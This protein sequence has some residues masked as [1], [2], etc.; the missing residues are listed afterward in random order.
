MQPL[1]LRAPSLAREPAPGRAPD[2]RDPP[3]APQSAAGPARS[4]RFGYRL[5]ILLRDLG[6]G[7]AGQLGSEPS[8]MPRGAAGESELDVGLVVLPNTARSRA[9][10]HAE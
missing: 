4:G 2:L 9:R 1:R 5:H 7:A 10:K 8:A 6:K 3:V